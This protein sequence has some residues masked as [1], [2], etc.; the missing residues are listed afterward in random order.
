MGTFFKQ[1]S[2]GLELTRLV[3]AGPNG[4]DTSRNVPASLHDNPCLKY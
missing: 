1:K 3:F 2:L 4:I